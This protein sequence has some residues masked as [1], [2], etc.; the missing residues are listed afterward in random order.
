MSTMTKH[1]KAVGAVHARVAGHVFACDICRVGHILPEKLAKHLDIADRGA[2]VRALDRLTSEGRV[3]KFPASVPCN[4]RTH[5]RVRHC[6]S[7]H[8]VGE[9]PRYCVHLNGH[10]S[11]HENEQWAWSDDVSEK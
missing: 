9:V 7:K 1:Q 6:S 11:Y 5:Y 4:G 10:E 2:V 8:T 3:C